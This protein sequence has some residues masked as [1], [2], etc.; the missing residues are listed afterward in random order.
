MSNY[1]SAWS[2]TDG[3]IHYRPRPRDP[4]GPLYAHQ[5]G[6]YNYTR[7]VLH[8]RMAELLLTHTLGCCRPQAPRAQ[9]QGQGL[10]VPPD[11]YRVPHPPS[12]PLLQDRRCPPPYLEVRVRHRLHPRRISVVRNPGIQKAIPRDR[13]QGVIGGKHGRFYAYSRH[14]LDRIDNAAELS[15]MV[16]MKNL[17]TAPST[18]LVPIHFTF[19][20][21]YT[22]VKME[23]S[24]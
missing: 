14:G 6:A 16:Q 24:I 20:C 18:R 13:E 19:S 12:V 17:F 2:Q 3:V 8:T 10:Q 21:K 11:S 23:H 9:P 22:H 1:A 4:R 15:R 5:E 7:L